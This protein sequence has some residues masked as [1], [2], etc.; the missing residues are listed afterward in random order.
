MQRN[1]FAR[2]E[3]RTLGR[4][5]RDNCGAVNCKRAAER[6]HCHKQYFLNMVGSNRL[7]LFEQSR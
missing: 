5:G 6:E 7:E 1:S 4:F 2:A 3:S